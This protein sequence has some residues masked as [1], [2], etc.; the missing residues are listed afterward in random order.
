M[1]GILIMK[2]YH[3]QFVSMKN[4]TIH[5]FQ[6][7]NPNT[8]FAVVQ[9][10]FFYSNRLLLFTLFLNICFHKEGFMT[11]FFHVLSGSY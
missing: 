11:A 10:K 2:Y 7:H 8:E 5:W 3:P 1:F 6:V 9:C 4:E